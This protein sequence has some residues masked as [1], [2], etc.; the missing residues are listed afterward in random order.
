MYMLLALEAAGLFWALF[1]LWADERTSQANWPW[2]RPSWAEVAFFGCGVA[3]LWTHYS[4]PIVLAAAGIAFVVRWG[5]TRHR[6][7]QR[8]PVTGLAAR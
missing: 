5:V 6:A 3:G 1:V 8:S 4:F 7:S 2:W